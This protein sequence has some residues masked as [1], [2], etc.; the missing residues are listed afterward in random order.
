MPAWVY[1]FRRHFSLQLGRLGCGMALIFSVVAVSRLQGGETSV[2]AEVA[3]APIVWR[4][5]NLEK[6]GGHVPVVQGQPVLARDGPGGPAVIFDGKR[7]GLFFATNPLSGYTQFTIELLFAPAEGGGT[8]QRFLHL[9]DEA[10]RRV[11][12]ES[13]VD[14]KGRWWLDT[15]LRPAGMG[16]GLTLIDP[17]K[18]HPTERWYWAALRYDGR[19]MSAFVNGEKELEGEVAFGAMSGGQTSIGVRLTRVS[20]F[21]GTI[22]E[23][24]FHPS[25]LTSSALQR[26]TEH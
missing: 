14:G 10:G 4:L 3:A 7:D 24:R 11:L 25:A 6:I 26:L 21:K 9:Q 19:S 2:A 12:I 22:R 15:F 5:D 23:V 16:R 17:K 20:W 18:T 8:E 1:S 13:R